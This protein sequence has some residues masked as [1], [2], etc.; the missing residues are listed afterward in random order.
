MWTKIFIGIFVICVLVLLVVNRAN[1]PQLEVTT[2]DGYGE[3]FGDFE[4][5]GTI[6]TGEE[7]L[8]VLQIGKA[9]I[10]VGENTKIRLDRIFEDDVR[11]FVSQGRVAV[12]ESAVTITTDRVSATGKNFELINYDFQERVT[13]EPSSGII[14]VSI[15][16][17]ELQ[18][19]DAGKEEFLEISELPPFT[20]VRGRSEK[21]E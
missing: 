9:I 13:V 16:H 19:V 11:L 3:I 21:S 2:L 15:N 5:G 18:T 7:S 17:Q 6:S 20:T 1:E 8:S 10:S 4:R 14:E 12:S